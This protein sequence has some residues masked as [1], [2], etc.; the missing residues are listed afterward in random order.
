[1][2]SWQGEVNWP[3]VRAAG[4]RFAYVRVSDGA[5]APDPQFARN[6]LEAARAGVLRGA[7]Q[8]FRPAEDPEEQAD[9]FLDLVGNP[10]SGDLPPALDVETGA[11]LDSD[12]VVAG[13]ERWVSRVRRATTMAPVIYTSASAWLTGTGNTDRFRKLALWI[14]HHEVACPNTPIAWRRWTFHQ[15]AAAGALEGVAGAVD[16]DLF[17]GTLGA[18]ERMR[19]GDGAAARAAWKRWR[20]LHPPA[21]E[22]TDLP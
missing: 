20:R 22:L 14:A 8:Y 2:S 10:M 15:S 5:T 17:Q 3:A 16:L 18:L 6:W 1:V 11:G 7:Y 13:I 19:L 12:V 21:P 4:A 9:L